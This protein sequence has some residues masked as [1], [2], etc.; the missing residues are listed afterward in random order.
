MSQTRL[1]Q[2]IEEELAHFP[3][4]QK[5]QLIAMMSR[6][7]SGSLNIDLSEYHTIPVDPLTFLLDDFYLGLD[8]EVY[9]ALLSEF[10]EINCGKYVEIVLTGAIGTAKTT[11]ALW[12]T[13]YQLYLV[14]CLY[15][16]QKCYG[17]DKASEI[18]FIFQS[19]NKQLA[20]DLDY[21]R[22]R[23]LIE[24]SPYFSKHFPFDRSIESEL[25][26]PNRIF[27]RPVS[28]SD[29]AAIG[30]NVMGGI[31]DELNYMTV[32]EGSKNAEGGTYDQAV[33]VYNSIARRRKSRFMKGGHVAGLLCLVSSRKYP[34]QFTDK[35]E[36]EAKKDG[37]IYVYDKC[38]WDI[39]PEGTFTG[40]WFKVFVGD[41]TRKPKILKTGEEA[42]YGVED[43]HLI[44]DI[45]IE[46]ISEFE[47]DMVNALREIAGV[48]TLASH[49]FIL[50]TDAIKPCFHPQ[51]KSIFMEEVVD[52]VDRMLHV[53]KS[54]FVNPHKPRFVHLDLSE[55]GDKTGL[56]IGH[57]SHFADIDRNDHIEKH[58]VIRIDGALAVQAPQGGEILY[59]KIRALL[60][61]LRELGM[62]IKWI[63]FDTFQSTDSRQ[64]LAQKGFVT[65][66]Q[67]MDT[68]NLPYEL[69][70]SAI[71]DGRIVAP[72][73]D[74]LQMELARLE[75]DTKKDKIDHPQNFSK[76]IADSLA[77][78][79]FG[80]TMRREI[81]I[82]HNINPEEAAPSMSAIRDKA[83]KA[84]NKTKQYS[85]GEYIY[86]E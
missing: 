4:A 30:Q 3:K 48:S 77:G 39:K 17:L 49:P 7:A 40:E 69:T 78:V 61:R 86:E 44:K 35:K 84:L 27:V 68:S 57:V 62:N 58:P 47:T 81:W 41:G 24:Q 46:Y 63:T 18:L 55:T 67:S 71:Y 16:P 60:Y 14:S 50:N 19:I 6:M 42:L 34:G 20:K 65:G 59:W 73:H 23:A 45:P 76:D 29:T 11:L 43:A 36:E 38:T 80:L 56:V 8:G 75:K 13:A 15:N 12:S 22:F 25:Q 21:G 32:T 82:D 51:V 85:G 53:N 64:V 1:E 2:I 54:A 26:F 33:A 9:P 66:I 31:I 37:T 74:L 70:K 52:F 72:E 28:G 79:V 83:D 10:E 5:M